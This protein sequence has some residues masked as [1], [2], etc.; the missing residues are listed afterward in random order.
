[1]RPLNRSKIAALNS[2]ASLLQYSTKILVQVLLTP[3][4]VSG[5]G[6][7]FY[8]VWQILIRSVGFISAADGRPTQALKWVIAN[9]QLSDDQ[10]VKRKAIGS[11]LG[12]GLIMM[13]VM[14][15][16]GLTISWFAPDLTG[17]DESQHLT[18]RIVGIL[19]TINLMLTVFVMLPESVIHGM[20]LSYK[21]MG[22][23]SLVEVAGGLLTFFAIESGMGIV[24]VAA[25]LTSQTV[26]LGILFWLLAKK[27][28]A[29]FGIERVRLT[30]VKRFFKISIWYSGWN[31]VQRVLISSDVVLIGLLISAVAVTEFTLTTYAT[32]TSITVLSMIVASA[33]P[34]LGGLIGNKEF[35][36]TLDLHME[37]LLLGL[38]MLSSICI[39]ILIWNK[40]FV[41]LWV[42][43][44][45]YTG[46]D[47]NFLMVLLSIQL[48]FIRIDAYLIDATL[49]IKRKV[50]LGFLASLL[51]VILATILGHQFGLYGV[52]LGLL[53]GKLV[54]N[55]CYPVIICNLLG[56]NL[57]RHY[58][59]LRF[60]LMIVM[61]ALVGFY[62]TGSAPVAN[63]WAQLIALSLLTGIASFLLTFFLVFSSVQREIIYLRYRN[64]RRAR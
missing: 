63:N 19:L 38:L 52:C 37:M 35:Q 11:A 9:E 58:Q 39:P 27:Y 48:L 45:Y 47:I 42:G 31:F 3:I 4:L 7:I 22:L 23:V 28:L 62:F 26:L 49:N 43:A 20:N 24:G 41:T 1:M 55:F 5:L 53:L 2:L 36:R 32:T 54:L 17:V 13:P 30:E 46:D 6:D 51:L 44:A 12:V 8:G 40:S 18:V 61:V 56:A 50:Q 34:A 21:R 64:F 60:P 33:M 59:P 25:A 29:W 10:Y 15:I 14:A 16:L 57:I